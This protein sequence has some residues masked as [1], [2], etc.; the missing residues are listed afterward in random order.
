MSVTTLPSLPEWPAICTLNIDQW[1]FTK[2]FFSLFL[3]GK[4]SPCSSSL[5][6]SFFH[7]YINIQTH[8]GPLYELSQVTAIWELMLLLIRLFI[9][10]ISHW[11]LPNLPHIQPSRR[12]EKGEK[13]K[14]LCGQPLRSRICIR[15][16]FFYI[17][18][19]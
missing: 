19:P 8:G 16:C 7:S 18:Q 6:R 10:L 3:G 1:N 9:F 5:T 13:D 2:P 17:I 11:T 15:V 12:K 14:I 4:T